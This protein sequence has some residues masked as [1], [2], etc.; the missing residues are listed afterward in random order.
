MAGQHSAPPGRTRAITF[1]VADFYFGN[2]VV[3]RGKL[4]I[5]SVKSVECSA[6]H[7]ELK[8]ILQQRENPIIDTSPALVTQAA[9]EGVQEQQSPQ[10]APAGDDG[11]RRVRTPSSVGTTSRTPP[12]GATT[13]PAAAAVVTQEQINN[14]SP[15]ALTFHDTQWFEE[16]Q[17]L[18]EK[19]INGPVVRRLWSIRN[20]VCGTTLE[21][22]CDRG[23][24]MSRLDYFLCMFP[25]QSLLSI[26]RL[27]SRQLEMLSKP[28]TTNG[29]ILRFFGGYLGN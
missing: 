15:A 23:D 10:A 29:E 2:N 5:R 4:S 21:Q 1:I 7:E 28:T 27:T 12:V 11:S 3:K 14:E 13:T 6:L 8:V 16:D 17:S 24:T 25:P 18:L 19:E 20:I 9:T 26:V 22:D